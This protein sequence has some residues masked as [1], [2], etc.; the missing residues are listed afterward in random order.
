MDIHEANAGG[1]KQPSG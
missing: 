1:A